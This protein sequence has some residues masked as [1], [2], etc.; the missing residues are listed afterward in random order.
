MTTVQRVVVVM[1]LLITGCTKNGGAFVCQSDEAG[2][3]AAEA[4]VDILS[5]K[6]RRYEATDDNGIRFDIDKSNSR[7]F[8]CVTKAESDAQRAKAEAEFRKMCE[9]ERQADDPLLEMSPCNQR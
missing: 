4:R 1:A 9:R 2:P 7:A 8:D 6:V 3:F 5:G